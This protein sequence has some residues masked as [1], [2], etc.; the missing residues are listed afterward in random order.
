VNYSPNSYLV[1]FCGKTSN[2]VTNRTAL[3]S[4]LAYVKQKIRAKM[5]DKAA[6]HFLRRHVCASQMI[7][8]STV[9]VF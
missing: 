6:G 8:Y 4:T 2:D 7:Q 9:H 1:Y 5:L 3:V